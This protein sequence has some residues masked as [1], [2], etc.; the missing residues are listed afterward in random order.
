MQIIN[1]CFGGSLYQDLKY[2]GLD[3]NSHRQD[4]NPCEYKHTIKVEKD[5]LLSRLFPNNNT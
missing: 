5:S 3:S 2:A 1:V 4:Y